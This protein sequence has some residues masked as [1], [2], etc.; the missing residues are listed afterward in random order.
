MLKKA[1]RRLAQ[2]IVLGALVG[3]GVFGKTQ[4]DPLPKKDTGPYKILKAKPINTVLDDLEQKKVIKNGFIAKIYTAVIGQRKL[5]EPGIYRVQP[6]MS[7]PEIIRSLSKPIKQL[8]RIPEGRW[9]A[10]VAETLDR[11]EVAKKDEYIALT[12]EPEKFKEFGIPANAKT[13]EG[14]LYPDTYNFPPNIGA[15]LII[16]RQLLNFK[17]RT[18][19]LG[20]TPENTL[21]TLII[22]SMLELESNKLDE[23][24]MISG[25]IQNRIRKGMR[26]QIDATVNYGMQLWRPLFYSDYTKVKSPFNTYLIKGL[27]PGPICSPTAESIEAALKPDKHP[28]LYYISLPDGRTLF[29]ATYQEH[30]ANIKVRDNIKKKS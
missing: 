28:Y 1:K 11:K 20:L 26:L 18:K 2:L 7:V 27:P 13:L 14:F 4:L 21:K 15:E 16:K 9:I 5:I 10:R 3:A 23:K 25:V 8:I 19:G 22:A 6:G 17:T 30:L 12:Q 29:S 24:K